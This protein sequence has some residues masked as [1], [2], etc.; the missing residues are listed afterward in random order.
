VKTQT[1]LCFTAASGTTFR[2]INNTMC[3]CSLRY[4]RVTKALLC[5]N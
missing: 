5:N 1:D 2:D 4:K 3:Y